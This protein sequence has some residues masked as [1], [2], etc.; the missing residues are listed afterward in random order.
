VEK[1]NYLIQTICRP[2]CAYYKPGKNEELL[3]RAAE[4]ALRLPAK[5]GEKRCGAGA[6]KTQTHA[7]EIAR[8][9]CAACGFRENDC[10][11]ARDAKAKPCGGYLYL[12]QILEAGAV[13]A[14]EVRQTCGEK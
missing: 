3:C 6:G 5:S 11:F 10:D 12:V 8:E 9:V 4:V 1:N 14:D 2:L 13:T 7:K